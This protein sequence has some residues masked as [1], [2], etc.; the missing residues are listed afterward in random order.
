MRAAEDAGFRARDVEGWS[1]FA[2][3]V[4]APLAQDVDHPSLLVRAAEDAGLRALP[5]LIMSVCL[6]KVS[7]WMDICAFYVLVSR[8]R[9]M[10]GLRLLTMVAQA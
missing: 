9:E 8:V 7:P 3:G 10:N 5:K 2:P 1:K 4:R 6:R